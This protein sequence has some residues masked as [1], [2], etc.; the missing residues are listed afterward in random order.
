MKGIQD[1]EHLDV[2]PEPWQ[3]FDLIGGTDAGGIVAL[4]I[5][6]LRMSLQDAKQAYLALEKKVFSARNF[7]GEGK[8]KASVFEQEVKRV[9]QK[10]ETSPEAK[11][12]DNSNQ[13][14]KTFVCAIPAADIT[15]PRLFR[16][17]AVGTREPFDCTIWEAARATSADPTLFT[18]IRI[19]EDG[20]VEDFIDG[21]LGFNNPAELI[22]EEAK[23]LFPDRSL[24]CLLSIGA[25]KRAAIRLMEP[26]LLQKAFRRRRLPSAL[27]ATVNDTEG[28]A[29]RI[30]KES[31]KVASSFLYFRFNVQYGLED[32]GLTDWKKMNL[33]FTYTNAY[34]QQERHLLSSAIE[35]LTS[36]PRDM[37]V[38]SLL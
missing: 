31:T 12:I 8:F 18:R 4:M 16:T 13:S 3:Y 22:L 37:G 28:V 23:R 9:V 14:T 34:L 33:I 25:G 15:T 7:F 2:P 36:R 5:G 10:K 11:M 17:Y 30:S 29:E 6:R 24:A 21:G 1:R 35:I 38:P 20:H 19:G 32:I 27:K 26:T